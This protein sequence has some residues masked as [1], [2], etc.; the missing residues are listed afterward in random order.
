M[1]CV[2]VEPFN[3]YNVICLFSWLAPPFMNMILAHIF[4]LFCFFLFLLF[5]YF[6][7]MDVTINCGEMS[8]SLT[9][10]GGSIR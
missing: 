3:F 4:V 8:D 1:V 6:S 2:F 7:F 10:S 5:I 9:E